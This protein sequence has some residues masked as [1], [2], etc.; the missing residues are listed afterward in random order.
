[1][2][3]LEQVEDIFSNLRTSSI[4]EEEAQEKL[5]QSFSRLNK[6]EAMI[7][8]KKM[9]R[10]QYETNLQKTVYVVCP[11]LYDFINERD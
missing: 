4:T 11:I 5:S 2:Q 1:M 9:D 7:V 10:Y 3:A 6:E 8:M